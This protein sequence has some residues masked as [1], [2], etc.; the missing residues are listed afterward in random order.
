MESVENDM[1]SLFPEED[2]AITTFPRMHGN[3]NADQWEEFVNND[4]DC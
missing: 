4:V 1:P 2:V 3:V